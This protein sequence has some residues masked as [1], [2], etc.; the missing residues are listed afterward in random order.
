[1]MNAV[2]L[3]GGMSISS[4]GQRMACFEADVS[5]ATF[6]HTISQSAAQEAEISLEDTVEQ[7]RARRRS[8]AEDGGIA[9][10]ARHLAHALLELVVLLSLIHI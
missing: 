4:A 7:I 2:V 1:M 9:E 3:N 10:L 5:A 6:A 8:E